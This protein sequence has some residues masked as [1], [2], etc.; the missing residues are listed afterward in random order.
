M[1][2]DEV[3]LQTR[4]SLTRRLLLA[5]LALFQQRG[6]L[7]NSI[8]GGLINDHDFL[9]GLAALG[10]GRGCVSGRGRQLLFVDA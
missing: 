3:G 6:Y 4:P 2:G 7:L 9:D 8:P 5:P 10:G 1:R